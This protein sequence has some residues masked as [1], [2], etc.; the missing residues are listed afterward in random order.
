MTLRKLLSSGGMRLQTGTQK[1]RF[2]EYAASL[3]EHKVKVL[4]IRSAKG[5]QIWQNTLEHLIGDTDGAK[6]GRRIPGGSVSFSSKGST[7]RTSS[8]GR[9]GRI[10]RRRGL[11]SV[12]GQPLAGH[13]SRHHESGEA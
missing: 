1:T 2:A 8:R 5:R 11:F 9:W 10:D 3:F 6:A 13:A 12:D 7:S 4:D